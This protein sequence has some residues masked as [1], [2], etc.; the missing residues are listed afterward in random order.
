[1]KR[2]QTEATFDVNAYAALKRS[3]DISDVDGDGINAE[4]KNGILSIDLPKK[5]HEK[6]ETKRLEI[7]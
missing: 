6:P 1:M 2:T 4:Y 3:F 7:K 5:K